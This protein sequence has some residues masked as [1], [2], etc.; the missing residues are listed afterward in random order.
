MCSSDHVD[1]SRVYVTGHSNG[2]LMTYTLGTASTERFAAIAPIGYESAPGDFSSDAL[3]PV[4]SLVGEYDSAATAALVEG[5]GTVTCLQ[6]WNAHNGVNESAVTASEQQ[7]GQFKT[8]TFANEDGV[9]LLRY[10]EVL[11]TAHIY[12]PEEPQE[13]WYGFFSKYARGEDGTL[14]Y[15]GEPVKASAYVSDS[16]WYEPAETEAE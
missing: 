7:D 10:T 5:N 4:W 8:I 11:R 14:Y 1:A 15:E 2:A 12:M 3:L 6:G 16:G 9:P 13:I